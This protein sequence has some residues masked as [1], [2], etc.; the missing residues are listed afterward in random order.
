MHNT[1]SNEL[2]Y[3]SCAFGQDDPHVREKRIDLV[4]RFC[5]EKMREGII[6]FCPLIHNYYI[7]RYGLPIGWSY[8][9]K[10]NTQLLKRCDRLF[11]L[12]LEGWERSEG[13]QAEVTLAR[14][15]NIPIEYHEFDPLKD[16]ASFLF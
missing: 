4:S 15:F 12:K 5:A 7:L 2:I 3:V 1:N 13:I 14:K 8:W 10:F 9:E 6:V 11:V 16:N